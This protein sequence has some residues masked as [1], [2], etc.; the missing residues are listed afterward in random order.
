M[1]SLSI[2]QRLSH[3][4]RH[5]LQETHD[6]VW[7]LTFNKIQIIDFD[8]VIAAKPDPIKE[9]LYNNCDMKEFNNFPILF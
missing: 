1:D 5:V 3:I 4:F 6:S 2:L 8:S 9:N 7:I